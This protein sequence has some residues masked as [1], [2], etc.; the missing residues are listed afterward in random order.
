MISR[1]TVSVP[2]LVA[3]ALGVV[4][5]VAVAASVIGSAPEASAHDDEDLE[6]TPASTISESALADNEMGTLRGVVG[7]TNERPVAG[8][9]A[10]TRPVVEGECPVMTDSIRRLYLAFLEREP[11]SSEFERD[12]ARYA[13]GQA[14]LEDLAGALASG[15]LFRTRYGPLGDEAFVGR[16]YE[17]TFGR[18]PTSTVRDHWTAILD[19]GYSR[20]AVMLALSES[21]EFVRRTDTSRPLSGYLNW[22]PEG[23]HWYCG[24]GPADDLAIRPLVEGDLYADYMFS[25]QGDQGTATGLTTVLDGRAR[26][27]MSSGTLPGGFSDYRW[28]G[29]FDGADNYGEAIDV[30]ANRRTSWVVVFYPRTIGQQRLGWQL[31]R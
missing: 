10:A 8:A 19:D 14:N 5:A 16:A 26:V 3:L 18:E 9:T 13:S 20:G 6:P 28:D 21:A 2:T 24:V 4:T 25:N 27:P 1:P 23:V 17:N 7:V 31:L 30:I 29:R 12:I 11:N 15:G 22:Y